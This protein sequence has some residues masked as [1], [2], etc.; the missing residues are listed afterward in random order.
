MT[1]IYEQFDR[2]FGNVTAAAILKDSKHVA[3]ITL[4]HGAAVTAYVHWLGLEMVSGRAGGGGYDRATAACAAA[5]RK[6]REPET[7][8]LTTVDREPAGRQ[9]FI[10]ALL[11]DGGARWQNALEAAGFTVCNVIA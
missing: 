10:T 2:A 1:K 8:S 3:N 11:R 6:L 7:D 5:V 4:K 9:L